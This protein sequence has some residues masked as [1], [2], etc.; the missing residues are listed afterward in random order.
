MNLR[1][2]DGRAIMHELSGLP[3]A[4]TVKIEIA[5]DADEQEHV[6]SA[7]EYIPKIVSPREVRDG[8]WIVGGQWITWPIKW[9]SEIRTRQGEYFRK[10]EDGRLVRHQEN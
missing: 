1:T 2:V 5:T 7:R 4:A 3:S 8:F 9:I 6:H 10:Q